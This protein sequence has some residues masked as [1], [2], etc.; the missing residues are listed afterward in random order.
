MRRLIVLS[1]LL[2]VLCVGWWLHAQIAPVAPSMA[3]DIPAGALLYL[4]AKDFGKL[5]REWNNSQE[6]TK[7]LGSANYDVLSRSRLI[8]RLQQAQGELEQTAGVSAQMKLL[9]QVA[10]TRSAFAF[11]NLGALK[12]VCITHLD[13]GAIE[14]NDLWKRRAQYQPREAAGSRST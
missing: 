13:H 10:G 11:Y 8:G 4:E 2:S 3:A 6:K 5:L 1:I 7:W 12:F 14:A 9:E